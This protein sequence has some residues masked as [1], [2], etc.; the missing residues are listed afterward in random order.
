MPKEI[1]FIAIQYP[2]CDLRSFIP[3]ETHRLRMPTFP[4]PQPGRDFLRAGGVAEWRR[5][6]GAKE[7]SGEEL[8]CRARSALKFPDRLGDICL[9]ARELN[10]RPSCAFRRYYSDGRMSR[11]DLGLRLSPR[12]DG[13][14]P[15]NPE[16]SLTIIKDCLE[17]PVRVGGEGFRPLFRSAKPLA[18]HLLRSTTRHVERTLPEVEDWWFVAGEPVLIVENLPSKL[19]QPRLGVQSIAAEERK[20]LI[21]YSRLEHKGC[22]FGV[23]W[24]EGKFEGEIR[25][26]IRLLRIHL[27]R[28]HAECEG[29]KGVL[30]ALGRQRFSVE[31]GTEASEN[32]QDYLNSSIG[33]LNRAKRFGF[34]QSELLDAALGFGD[35]VAPGQRTTL[36]T[37]LEKARRNISRNVE[38]FIKERERKAASRG[39]SLDIGGDLKAVGPVIIIQCDSIQESFNQPGGI[40]HGRAN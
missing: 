32:L 31:P 10:L 22:T 11:L 34:D 20:V 12:R 35:L 1:M 26:R 5:R 4:F 29:L 21:G 15:T 19:R 3:Q 27:L 38:N 2:F 30:R 16:Q 6:G 23:W 36:L 9:G 18:D 33:L 14:I 39:A 28:L 13:T 37:E 24:L 8:Y 17:L 25:D 40:D 7:W